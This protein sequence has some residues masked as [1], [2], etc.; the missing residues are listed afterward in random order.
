[1]HKIT[2]CSNMLIFK[3]DITAQTM[4]ALAMQSQVEFS[5][6]ERYTHV[7]LGH[8]LFIVHSCPFLLQLYI[9]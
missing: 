9:F 2:A 1:M 6:F 3:A 4:V 8:S 7:E 5:E